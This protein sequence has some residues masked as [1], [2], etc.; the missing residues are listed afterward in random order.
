METTTDIKKITL[1]VTGMS[2]AACAVSVESMLSHTKGILNAGVNY[3]NQSVSVSY[4]PEL[5][6]LPEM[7]RVLQS[8]GY[9]LIIEDNEEDAIAEQERIQR[10]RYKKLKNNAIYTGILTVPVVILG[11]FLMD[12]AYANYVMFVLSAPVLFVF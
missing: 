3:A 1:P 8:I 5:V 12:W 11:M 9:G 4:D 2:C 10:E 7:D 6:D